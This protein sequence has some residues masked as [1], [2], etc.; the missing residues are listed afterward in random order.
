MQINF[1]G[2]CAVC[3]SCGAEDFAVLRP[4]PDDAMDK[5]ACTTCSTEVFFDDLRA[6]IGRTALARRQLSMSLLP[7]T[8]R[9]RPEY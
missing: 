2:I 6:M 5:L 1:G 9:E 8:V 7:S 4:R 3:Y